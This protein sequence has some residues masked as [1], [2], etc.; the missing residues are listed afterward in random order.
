MCK[1]RGYCILGPYASHVLIASIHLLGDPWLF[2]KR[3]AHYAYRPVQIH[4]LVSLLHSVI[5]EVSRYHCSWPFQESRHDP[6][7]QVLCRNKEPTCWCCLCSI[8]IG[9]ITCSTLAGVTHND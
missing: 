5:T 3:I 9:K 2:E 4:L 7:S 6:C 1:K 8:A